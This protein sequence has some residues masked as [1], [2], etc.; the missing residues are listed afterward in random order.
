MQMLAR[1]CMFVVKNAKMDRQ[2][3]EVLTSP[4]LSV[5]AV[6]LFM[7][8]KVSRREIR[9]NKTIEGTVSAVSRHT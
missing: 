7:C 6:S 8:E 4:L 3:P 5:S 9:K 2:M 1:V